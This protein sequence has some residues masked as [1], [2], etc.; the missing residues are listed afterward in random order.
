MISL[1]FSKD[2]K[3][4]LVVLLFSIL[5]ELVVGST[6]SKMQDNL[7][8]LPGLLIILPGTLALRGNIHSAMGS[9]LGTTMHLGLIPKKF[10]LTDEFKVNIY[11]TLFL[12]V[13]ITFFLSFLATTSAYLLN[14]SV[15][16]VSVYF[17]LL[18]IVLISGTCASFILS[19][20]GIFLSIYS[21]NRGIDPDDVLGPSLATVGDLITII[22]IFITA[23]LVLGA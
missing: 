1:S 13:V 5:I 2:I 4:S 7:E 22:F 3:Y 12:T 16:F 9:R 11:S 14:D 17:K 8:L 10:K 20:F 19:F 21:S 6:I 18:I 15:N 23:N